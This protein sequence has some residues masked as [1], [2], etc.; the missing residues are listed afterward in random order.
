ML[1]NWLIYLDLLEENNYNTTS[2]RLVTP[3]IFS[4]S[5]THY[6][7][8]RYGYDY[9]N[10]YGDGDC[11]TPYCGSGFGDGYNYNGNGYRAGYG[12]R[13]GNGNLQ[14]IYIDEE[15]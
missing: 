7:N 9:G 2:L 5:E 6:Y 8:Y 12:D 3:T 10:G 1:T 15:H 14:L 13:Y 11:N 4:I